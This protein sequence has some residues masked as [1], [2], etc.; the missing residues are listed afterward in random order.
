VVVSI[1]C[2]GAIFHDS[3]MFGAANWSSDCIRQPG[4]LFVHVAQNGYRLV[5]V[6]IRLGIHL[7]RGH[8]SAS[9]VPTIFSMARAASCRLALLQW[10]GLTLDA[11]AA[12]QR[13]VA[14]YP[15]MLCWLRAV[16]LEPSP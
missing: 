13:G 12:S 11:R 2:V 9:V 4:H 14:S 1:C 5:E 6:F 3:A 15:H 7:G 10:M 8:D 16:P